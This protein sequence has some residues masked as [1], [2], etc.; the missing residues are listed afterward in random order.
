MEPGPKETR[1]GHWPGGRRRRA[2]GYLL[3]L[4]S[5]MLVAVIGISALMAQRV[6]LRIADADADL[7]TARFYA[8]SA[9]EMG[10][11]SRRANPDWRTYYGSG[12]WAVDE[13]IG[14][15]TYQLTV[16]DADDGDIADNDED[17]VLMTGT[18]LV[19]EARHALSV[20]LD[21]EIEPFD[22][23]EVA[24][25]TGGKININFA[26]VDSNQTICSGAEMSASY[27]EVRADVEAGTSISGFNFYGSRVANVAA[28]TMPDA[29]AF[30]FYTTYGT[31]VSVWSLP[32][33]EG[34]QQIGGAVISAASNPFGT[35]N[36]LGI[37]VID[38]QGQ[39]IRIRES[40]IVGTLV[41]TNVGSGSLIEREMNWTAAVANYPVLLVDGS[42]AIETVDETLDE[43]EESTNFNP[44][45]T[46][47]DGASDTDQ[48][49]T[50]PGVIEGLVYVTGDVAFSR[51]PHLDG[52]TIV[53]GDVTI[54]ADGLDINYSDTYIKA[55]PPGFREIVDMEEAPNSWRQV[56]N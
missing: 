14:R 37:Y 21:A 18:G 31:A 3:V 28:R 56:V 8:R 20:T 29:S 1:P 6:R 50:Y 41:L 51:Y 40:R 49:D 42:I 46:P 2:S 19:G 4:G 11:L 22:C 5:A 10:K 15:G 17:S 35:A 23:L 38:C 13:P 53:G 27:G 44:A 30:D 45:D 36:A 47:Y 24:L 48:V 7:L 54:D 32:S 9:I 25:L 34:Y 12:S 26:G 52:V 55:P 33:V 16:E 43:S 39:P